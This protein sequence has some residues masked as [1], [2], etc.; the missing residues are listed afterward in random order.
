M[1]RIACV[2][3]VEIYGTAKRPLESWRK[4]PYGLSVIAACLE[5]AGH[6]VRC[7]V[8]CPATDIRA[9]A[10]EMVRDFGCDCVAASAVSTQFPVVTSLCDEVKRIDPR[11][12]TVVGGAHPSLNPNDAIAHPAVDAV[13]V[14]EG[15]KAM[16]A[17]AAAL[18]RHEQPRS[19]AGMWFKMGDG[20]ALD[21]TPPL[22]FET[23]ID[24]LPLINLKHWEPW[25][26]E[27][28]RSFRIVVGRGCPFACTYCSNHALR[29]VTTGKYLRVRSP[30]SILQELRRLVDAYPDVNQVFL[31]AETITAIPGFAIELCKRLAEF[32]SERANP[33]VF[34]A[35]MTVTTRL[36]Q[37][38]MQTEELLSAYRSA[39]LIYINIGLESGSERI[40]K[41]ILNRPGYT[42]AD[43]IKFCQTAKK[44]GI[45]IS[46]F[47]LLGLPTETVQDY[48]TTV[49]VLRECDPNTIYESIYYP[50][51]GTKL[52]DLAAEMRL[53]DP[54]TIDT[55]SERT[56]A[57]LKLKD[58]PQ[59]RVRFE[60]IFITWRVFHARKGLLMVAS[61]MAYKA[62]SITPRM[63]SV[64]LR[65]R[66]S[67]TKAAP[68]QS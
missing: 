68:A 52:Y 62:L 51:P 64:A 31:E 24:E 33:I 18:D 38:E 25:V 26:K 58:F 10:M 43:L 44:H 11:I 65:F 14:G 66:S 45:K 57:H 27:M 32:N 60:Y 21:R 6:Q 36:A 53:F 49:K 30:E 3:S 46:L 17:I 63:L 54:A 47:V 28:D 22:P 40:R 16:V 12:L 56:R 41:E 50:Y 61:L 48:L 19:I 4:V 37:S 13:C 29:R 23:Q 55:R 2:F 5:A 20:A 34:R 59:W 1:A 67:W 9:F 7:W 15:E 39:N 42:N 35:N 8:L